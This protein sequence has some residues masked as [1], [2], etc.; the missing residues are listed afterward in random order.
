MIALTMALINAV[1]IDI[2]MVL[3]MTMKL[4]ITLETVETKPYDL[5]G[6]PTT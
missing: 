6:S 1:T 3:T 2:T 5:A 4:A